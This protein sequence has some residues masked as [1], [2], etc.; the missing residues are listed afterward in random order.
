MK[1]TLNAEK[2]KQLFEEREE[3]IEIP[4][5]TSEIERFPALRIYKKKK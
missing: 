3:K 4:M 2:V 1:E 5:K